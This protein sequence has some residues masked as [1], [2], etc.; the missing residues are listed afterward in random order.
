MSIKMTSLACVE[1]GVKGETISSYVLGVIVGML[2]TLKYKFTC[3]HC[4]EI[5]IPSYDFYQS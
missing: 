5:Y 4:I 3:G 2:D 1:N